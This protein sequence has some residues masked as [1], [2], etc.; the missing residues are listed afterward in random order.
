MSGSLEGHVRVTLGSLQGPFWGLHGPLAAI[1]GD[2]G[3]WRLSPG[4]KGP[5]GYRLGPRAPAA[6]AGDHGGGYRHGPRGLAAIARDQGPQRLSPGTKGPS[7]YR[8]EPRSAA[9]KGRSGGRADGLVF[10]SEIFEA[11][12]LFEM[13]VPIIFIFRTGKLL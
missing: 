13:I 4:T 3:A 5:G 11:S 10:C 8:Q 12:F 9:A 6:I 2:Q 1:A 7:G